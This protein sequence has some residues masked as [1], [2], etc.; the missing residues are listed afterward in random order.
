MLTS[1]S[2]EDN[3]G[4]EMLRGCGTETSCLICKFMVL[5]HC[6]EEQ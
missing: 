3:D 6:R 5:I 2:A 4:D 1:E